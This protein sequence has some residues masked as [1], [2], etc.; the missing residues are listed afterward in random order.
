MRQSLGEARRRL[1]G[2]FFPR[3]IRLCLVLG[4]VLGFLILACLFPHRAYGAE[5]P[6]SYSQ[7]E[8]SLWDAYRKG[9]LIRL[10]ILAEDDSPQAQALKLTV[11][12]AVLEGFSNSLT[13]QDPEALY[14][15]LQENAEAMR[16]LAEETA[17]GEGFTGPVTAQVG[18]MT[19]PAKRYGQVLLPQGEYRALRIILG[20]GEGHN[21]WCVLFPSLCLAVADEEPWRTP[22]EKQGQELPLPLSESSDSPTP[23]IHWDSQRIL[24]QW[25][26][27][28][29]GL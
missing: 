28:P 27:L 9:T 26:C 17:R 16:Q 29:E 24:A 13:A 3:F 5:A 8:Q 1:G 2:G 18:V 14:L 21:W 6:A 11:R 19:L 15:L 10:H 7:E 12:D 23:V 20:Q 25:L 4:F 22:G